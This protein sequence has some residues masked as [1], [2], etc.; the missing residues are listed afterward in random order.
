LTLE[1]LEERALP[2]N[3]SAASTSDLI[4][5]ILSANASATPSTITLGAPLVPINF[6]FSSPYNIDAL[7]TITG[8]ITIVG[9]NDD[10]IER[11]TAPGTPAFRLFEVAAGG[12]LTLQNLTLE[13]GLATSIAPGPFFAVG[14]AIASSGALNLSGVTVKSNKAVASSGIFGPIGGVGGAALGGGLFVDGGSVSL[15]N[16]NFSANKAYG[17][18]GGNGSI[19]GAGGRALG[20]GLF[21]SEGSVSLRNN[22]FKGNLAVGGPGG[23]GIDG[24]NGGNGGHGG[25]GGQAEGGGLFVEGA[26]ASV[27]SSGDTFSGN[28]AIGGDGGRG[29]NGSGTGGTGGAGGTGGLA[30]DGQGGAM[31][32]ASIPIV[33]LSNDSLHNN[34]AVGG[35]GGHGGSGGDGANVPSDINIGAG[36]NGGHGGYGGNGGD[37]DG[38]GLSFAAVSQANLSNDTL[39]TNGA[40]GG[41]GGTGGNGG[42]G[43]NASNG[44]VGGLGGHG[45]QGTTGSGG[46]SG[47]GGN[48]KG[49]GL[50]VEFMS[51]VTLSYDTL[52]HNF[53]DGS[54][55]GLGG[56]G[57]TGGNGGDGRYGSGNGGISGSGGD[58]DG[59]ALDVD[60]G[61]NVFL[62]N[63]T[64]NNN[65]AHGG[66]GGF[67][68]TGGYAGFNAL[69]G[70]HGGFS[71][72]GGVAEGG[73]IDV[74]SAV[75]VTLSA[76]TLNANDVIGGSG[77]NGGD[78][79]GPGGYGGQGGNGAGGG[80]G[81]SARGGGLDVESVQ[82]SVNLT[83]DTLSG[84]F[85]L[86]GSGGNAGNAGQAGNVATTSGGHGGNGG[87]GG[88]GAGGGLYVSMGAVTMLNDT[89]SG[90]L[91]IGGNAG[92]G[93][94][95]STSAG[96]GG[97]G[98][99]FRGGGLC[100]SG[101]DPAVSLANTLIAG[102]VIIAG[103]FGVGGSGPDV[104]GF[105][106]S[107]DHDLIGDEGGASGFSLAN[108]DILNQV[109]VGLDPNGLL[110]NGGPTKTIAL[111]PNSLAIDAGDN[112]ATGLPAT[113][114]RGFA[115]I[116]GNAVD[117]GAYEFGATPATAGMS[118]RSNAVS[119]GAAGGTITYTLTVSNSS[120]TAQSNVTVTD[121]LPANA[122]LVSW[123][124]AAG[125][126]SSA[127]PAGS[128][129]GS[130]TAWIN[131]LAAHSSA[132]FTL[133]VRIL[134]ATTVATV[135]S[136]SAA[137]APVAETSP[138]GT[139]SVR[140]NTPV[141][142]G[143]T[144]QVD[145]GGHLL[146]KGYGP[147]NAISIGTSVSGGVLVDYDGTPFPF[148]PGRVSSIEVDTASA[149]GAVVTVVATPASVPLTINSGGSGDEVDARSG[150]AVHGPFIGTVDAILG[151]LTVNGLPDG[152]TTFIVNDQSVSTP[153]TYTLTGTATG[154]E[155]LSR[156][157]GLV[158]TCNTVSSITVNGGSGG[159]QFLD[160]VLP[161]SLVTFNGG[162]GSN[163]LSATEGPG[164][165]TSW[166]ITGAGSGHVGN[167]LV[168]TGMHDLLGQGNV[169]DFKFFAGGSIAGTITGGGGRDN[170][171][172]YANE[173]G[174]VTVNLQTRAAPQIAGGAPGGFSGITELEGSTAVN[175]TLIGP[176]ADTTWTIS[177]ANGGAG[178]AGSFAFLF[179]QFQNL[180]GGAGVDVFHFSA[181]GSLSGSLDGGA[182]PGHQGN[183]L[184]YSA[185]AAPITV[186]LQTGTAT[187]VAGGVTKI[188]NVH[189]DDGG[190]T[191]TGN[192]QGNILIGGTGNDKITGGSG[193][194]LLIGDAG[195]DTITGGSGGDILIGDATSFD[196]MTAANEQALMAFLAEWQSAD[197][198]TTRF[199][200]INT[201]TGGGLNG[202]FKLNFGTTV[203]DDHAADTLIAAPSTVALDWFFKGTGDVLQNV[204]PGEHINNN[205]PAAFKDRTV[206]SP[207]PE[208]SLA[209][210]SG[211]ITD[212]DPGDSFTLVVKWG[213]GTRAQTYTFPPGSNGRRISVSHRYRDEGSYT[214]ALS[215][216]DPTG[217]A[218]QAT[219]AVTVT[220]VAPVVQTGGDVTL[221]TNGVLQRTGSFSNPRVDTS[222]AAVDYG[223]GT[224]PQPLSLRNQQFV[225]HYKYRHPGTYHVVVTVTD[226][227]GATGS[228][229][230]TVTVI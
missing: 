147:R 140:F 146:V 200:D 139:N 197:S 164:H 215:W 122:T 116:V 7:P 98:G 124:A 44:G 79:G 229:T 106:A 133:V 152:H 154:G 192:N 158:A 176:D 206:T 166:V 160:K 13:G 212:P 179:S 141:L 71:G 99:D 148:A 89:V 187:G 118:I 183:W 78:G 190:N 8:N 4:N 161:T 82:T 157:G 144:I 9:T 198:Y 104:S 16:D 17:G 123:T 94:S 74:V 226:D 196:T 20:G 191:L 129:S 171:L 195:P 25:T 15:T 64:L 58:G 85:A 77:G 96:T 67:G 149:G 165:V 205:T 63:D 75:K 11:S 194:S 72:G 221:P 42:N 101:N 40:A 230:F 223:D 153:Q 47:K 80:S 50:F 107:S 168:F 109:P 35:D 66:V 112:N 88:A 37:G 27:T 172:S 10:I 167:A 175:N 150:D 55:G 213:D 228:D 145:A 211:T 202:T 81:G 209:T 23:N 128:S 53:A 114:Q 56:L 32:F 30:G 186:N 51:N 217:P 134:D 21:V 43:G 216:T 61:G 31:A 184:D 181:G 219:L 218:N 132:T 189:G 210:L 60:G 125:W 136:N 137:L 131:S 214:I 38:G 28:E 105:V 48:G 33:T 174:P 5:D 178:S 151:P 12:S 120:A 46:I 111:E 29:G 193:A 222:T 177:A 87:A 14:G 95:G 115:R 26:A 163:S 90:N 201:G 91:V 52:S 156:S 117:I 59:G 2:S 57:G 41:F 170:L 18:T 113:D 65:N 54:E 92:F 102:D 203:L 155:V 142:A 185:L 135:I 24:G 19:A 68:F 73:A 188:Q 199:F 110:N 76:D 127:P 119:S 100:V 130:V 162:S 143:P 86:G 220:E 227:D 6:I 34:F 173:A 93:G 207:I 70:L 159:N 84:N 103:T 69:A 182:A 62:S 204:E 22:T 1:V 169:D 39:S 36:G 180:V 49:G 83:D 97:K 108:G 138:P 224:G 3:Y 208:G 121:P 45:G 225:L 126:S